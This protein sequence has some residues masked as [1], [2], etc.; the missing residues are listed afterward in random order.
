MRLRLAK[1]QK[2]DEKAWKIRAEGMDRY[3]DVNR[4]LHPQKLPF[5]L[6]IIRTKLINRH[7]NNLLAD[8]FGI[9]K[10]RELIGRKY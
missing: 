9:D 3:K 7:H 1:L 8:Y 4:V 2:S 10:T 5:V 6:K